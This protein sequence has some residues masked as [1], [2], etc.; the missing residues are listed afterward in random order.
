MD[1]T[2]LPTGVVVTIL[3]A[4][5]L[6]MF[7]GS[8]QLESIFGK[9]DLAREP[10][11]RFGGAVALCAVAL[12]VIV[13]GAP[14]TEQKYAKMAESKEAALAARD[15]Q[16]A[17]AELFHTMYDNKLQLLMVDVRSENDYNLFHLRGARNV[18]IGAVKT[19]VPELLA[20]A[21]ANRV[22]V[23]M[24]NDEASATTAWKTFVAEAIPNVYILEGG[25][26]NWLA[27]FGQDEPTITA[28]DNA[29]PDALD[30]AFPAALGDRYECAAPSL[31]EHETLEYTPKIKLQLRRDKSGGGCG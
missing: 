12:G 18:P 5:A 7:W 3:V 14:S 8:E 16:I 13:I 28:R 24:S 21:A 19:I 22:I 4:M 1:W 29:L 9:R 27:F 2:G 17:P 31:I 23:V 10:K 26:N 20:Q 6:F 25:V 11:L 30:Y 15:V